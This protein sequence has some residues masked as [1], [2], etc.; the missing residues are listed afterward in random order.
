MMMGNN[1]GMPVRHAGPRPIASGLADGTVCKSG[2]RGS[3]RVEPGVVGFNWGITSSL[4]MFSEGG[5]V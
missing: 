2:M 3:V 5:G 1:G 4:I